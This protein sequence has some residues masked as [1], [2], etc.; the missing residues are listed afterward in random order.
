MLSNKS[1]NRKKITIV[2]NEQI[3]TNDR[4]IAKVLNDFFSN[5]FETVNIP[6]KNHT[7]SII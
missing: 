1:V 7:N 4:R 6:Q 3:I 2:D 5:I